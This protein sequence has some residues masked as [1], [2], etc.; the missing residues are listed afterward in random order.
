MGQEAILAD[1]PELKHKDIR[2]CLRFAADRERKLSKIP[3]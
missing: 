3:A 1:F 2:A